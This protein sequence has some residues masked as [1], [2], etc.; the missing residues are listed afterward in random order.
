MVENNANENSAENLGI[1]T[2]SID[3]ISKKKSNKKNVIIGLILLLIIIAGTGAF[4]IFNNDNKKATKT[5][6]TDA[7]NFL[8]EY[9]MSGNSLD[10]FDL[11]FLK[12]GERDENVIYSPLSI[13]YA[14]SMLSEGTDGE[15]KA[16]INALIGDY[17]SNKYTNS[18]NLSLA[19]AFFVENSFKDSVKDSY[20]NDLKDKYGAEVIYDSFKTPDV[21]NKWVSNKTFGL[22][23][24]LV[25]DVSDKQFAL[26]NALA[27]DMEWKK[28]IQATPENWEDEYAID[29]VHQNYWASVPVFDGKTGEI[30]KFNNGSINANS[31]EIGASINNY[32]IVNTLG[33]DTIRKFITEEYTKWS[34]ENPNACGGANPDVKTFVNEYISELDS[35]YKKVDSST[36]FKFYDDEN[37]KVFAKELKEYNGTTLEYIGVMPKNKTLNEYIKTISAK[38]LNETINKTKTI[39]LDNFEKGS[40]YKI[41]GGIPLF[42]YDYKLNLMDDL[43]KL[44][45][46]D[47]FTPGKANLSKIVSDSGAFIDSAS[48]KANIEFSNDG[49][50][51]AAATEVGGSGAGDCMFDYL[52]EVPVVEI[53]LTF[54]NP[55]LYIIRDKKSGE[56]WFVG[57]VYE[58]SVNNVGPNYGDR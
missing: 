40:I 12:L 48:H 43:Q 39:E 47:I 7:T 8:S 38:N 5:N 20:T 6:E 37:V 13:K 44:G 10:E 28:K 58:P 51:A 4:L 52:Y 2:E 53:D 41:T 21:I 27:I 30:V 29:Y 15:S 34:N 36:D 17:K 57:T 32:D 55:Y 16:Q 14:L 19:N 45:V 35:N 3:N 42:K 9:R 1:N 54:N 26:V 24:N 25:D 49:I 33:E 46:K 18:S 50:K 11:S 22:I 23:N 31:V 56:V